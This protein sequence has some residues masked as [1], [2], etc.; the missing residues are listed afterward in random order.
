V[1]TLVFHSPAAWVL[2]GVGAALP[3]LD[4][5]FTSGLNITKHQL[6]RALTHNVFFAFAVLL[7]N[8]YLGA[9]VLL[10]IGL[11]LL[12]SPTDRG[13]EL[14]F[15]LGRIVK[16]FELSYKGK[17]EAG[18]G[19]L[20]FLEDPVD[21]LVETVAYDLWEYTPTP[22]RR[23]YGP[24]KNSR[25]ADWFTFYFSLTLLG[26]YEQTG[27]GVVEWLKELLTTAFM[28]FGPMVVGILLFYSV[29]ELWRRRL[30]SRVSGEMKPYVLAAMLFGLLLVVYQARMLYSPLKLLVPHVIVVAVLVAVLIG[31][32][33]AYVHVRL[34]F[35]RIVM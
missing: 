22:W 19:F 31:A 18:K 4:R 34:R 27:M 15:P 2:V 12:T 33:C 26:L 21:M 3:D 24:F 28:G 10:H 30:Q 16:Q 8:F 7:F 9:G 6:H 17:G 23:V 5:E 1:S 25:F 29:G 32:V 35:G 13:V 11:D 14:F 20:W